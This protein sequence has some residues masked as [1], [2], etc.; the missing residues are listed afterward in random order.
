VPGPEDDVV[1]RKNDVVTFD[2]G[3]DGKATCNKLQIDPKGG[4]TFKT[5]AGKLVLNPVGGIESF[6]VIRLD[7][8][9]SASDEFEIRLTGGTAEKRTVK[10]HKGSALLLYGKADLPGG[11]CNVSLV[12]SKTNDQ[13]EDILGLVDADGPTVMIDW[14]RTCIQDIKLTAK[15]IDNTGGK[16][17]ERLKLSEN[18]F[19]GLSR[20]SCQNCDTPE[21]ASNSFGADRAKPVEEAAINVSYSPLAEI[22]NNA[23]H[24]GF[25]IGITVNY[26]ADSVLLGNSIAKCTFGITGGYGIPNTMIKQTRIIGCETGVKLEGASGVL[27]DLTVEG[28][29]TGFLLQNSTLQLMQFQVKDLARNGVAVQVETGSLTLLNCDLKPEQFKVLAQAPVPGKPVIVPVT[30]LQYLIVSVK[31]AP[32]DAQVEVRTN[33]APAGPADPNVRNTPAAL[34]EGLTPLPRTLNPLIVKTWSYDNTGK[35]LPAPDYNINVLGPA[36]KEGAPRPVLKTVPFHPKDSGFRAQPNDKT[37][38]LEVLAK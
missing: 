15:K 27:E 16:A 30:S 6:G 18:R 17:N 9:K 4:L 3:D 33:P 5:T 13:K 23:I 19:T 12:S 2:R 14:Q 10:L 25:A 7:G 32:A 8:T 31:E 29:T 36:P 22:K 38:S 24:G 1:I 21:I 11:R 28:A 34:V 20:V 26:Q 35:L 37:P